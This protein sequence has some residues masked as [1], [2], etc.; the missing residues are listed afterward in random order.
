MQVRRISHW[1]F[2]LL[3]LCLVTGCPTMAPTGPRSFKPK[4]TEVY[5]HAPSSFQ[6]PPSA[7]GFDRET[8]VEYDSR[9]ENIG[10]GYNHPSLGIA[11]TIYVYPIPPQGLDS[12]LK[13]H[14][15]TCKNDV[16]RR[17]G[18]KLLLEKPVQVMPGGKER[19]G[20]YASFAYTELFAQARQPLHSEL[21]LFTHGSWFI[22]CRAS[23][24]EGQRV[25]AAPMVRLLIN[26]LVW[27]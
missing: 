26:E 6:F 18:A 24:P 17:P 4:S 8:V 12:T 15:E 16:L 5:T 9:G 1:L 19:S 3:V 10:V 27:P 21:F 23:Y 7:Q 25:A 20:E 11:A 22:K 2:S 14:F 13:G